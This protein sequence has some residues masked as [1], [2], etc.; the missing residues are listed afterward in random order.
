MHRNACICK[1]DLTHL[2]RGHTWPISVPALCWVKCFADLV[3]P[4]SSQ[5]CIRVPNPLPAQASEANGA[6]A[7]EEAKA[8]SVHLLL[9][10]SS[11]M[12]PGRGSDT[13]AQN[14]GKGREGCKGRRR[15]RGRRHINSFVV[16]Q[17]RCEYCVLH[18]RRFDLLVSVAE[19]AEN[20]GPNRHVEK[21]L[22]IAALTGL[23]VGIVGRRLAVTSRPAAKAAPPSPS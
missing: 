21:E 10:P 7:K 9:S 4:S 23:G 12:L 16:L 17:I 18:V 13:S 8:G 15:R 3:D 2:L 14:G 5:S 1:S 19:P 11:Q 6:K 20:E 22:P